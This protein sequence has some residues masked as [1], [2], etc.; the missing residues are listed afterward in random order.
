[1]HSRRKISLR[2]VLRAGAAL[3]LGLLLAAA[4]THAVGLG[5]WPLELAHHFIPHFT[6]GA[7]ALAIACLLA[8]HRRMAG[9]AVLLSGFFALAW[10]S[11]PIHPARPSPAA[12][13][14]PVSEHARLLSLLT[15]NVFVLNR[16]QDALL[17]WLADHPADVVALQE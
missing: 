16:Q 1:V 7:A 9:L 13:A 6:V 3:A 10:G 5:R 12:G 4:L 2:A 11:A 8:R 17:A 14:D 15:H